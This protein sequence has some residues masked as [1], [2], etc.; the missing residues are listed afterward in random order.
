MGAPTELYG[1]P[2]NSFVADFLGTSNI[3]TGKVTEIEEGIISMKTDDGL[4]IKVQ[5][6]NDMSM[7]LGQTLTISVRPENMRFSGQHSPDENFQ[8]GE[9]GTYSSSERLCVITSE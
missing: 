8:K 1:R 5:C 7:R 2:I 6:N 4:S 3:I 9:F